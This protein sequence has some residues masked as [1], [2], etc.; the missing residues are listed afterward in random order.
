[1]ALG[2]PICTNTL[3]C[4][5]ELNIPSLDSQRRL[6]VSN[7]L[8]RCKQVDDS[9]DEEIHIDSNKNYP[10]LERERDGQN[11]REKEKTVSYLTLKS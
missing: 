4:Y 6:A 11:I 3:K 7:Y 5:S 9:M 2:L 10:K 1:M 8:L